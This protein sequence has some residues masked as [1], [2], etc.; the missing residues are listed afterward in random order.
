M[1]RQKVKKLQFYVINIDNPKMYPTYKT[2][3]S[4]HAF[5]LS[6]RGVIGEVRRGA[7]F[8]G[9]MH[10]HLIV[11]FFYY[12]HLHL[13]LLRSVLARCGAVWYGAV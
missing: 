5:N 2:Q 7:V 13:H 3:I 4:L 11:Q 6:T 10:L 12:M 8:F 9:F 1:M